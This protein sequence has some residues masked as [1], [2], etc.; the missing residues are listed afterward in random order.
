[1]QSI[2]ALGGIA[3]LAAA[4]LAIFWFC[5][6]RRNFRRDLVLLLILGGCVRSLSLVIFAGVSLTQGHVQ[7]DTN[8]C[9]V[10]GYMN[11]VG[12][13]SCGESSCTHLSSE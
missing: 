1:M 12:F 3:G 9:R 4:L 7:S 5:L 8:F 6:M 11:M 13:L 10:N 2:G